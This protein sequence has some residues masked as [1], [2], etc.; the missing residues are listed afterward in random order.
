[1]EHAE[2]R[3]LLEIAAVEPGGFDRLAAGD[4]PESAALAGH[5]AGCDVCAAELERLRRA[6]LVIRDALRTAPP[7]ELRDR[8]LAFVAAVGR[9]R[10]G[11]MAEGATADRRAGEP[12]APSAGGRFAPGPGLWAASLAAAVVIAILGTSLL[13]GGSRDTVIQTQATQ[14]ASLAKAAAWSLRIDAQPDAKYVELAA[15]NGTPGVAGTLA[16]S[17]RSK[18][19]VV[20]AEGLEHPPPGMQYRCWV[21]IDGSRRRIG[22]MF[23]GG[24]VAYWVGAVDEI[25]G[26]GPGTRF[27]VSLVPADGDSLSTEPVLAGGL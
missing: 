18:E 11:A 15:P 4:T 8:T 25:A 26:V 5:I 10:G 7:P 14:I 9:P 13:V 24:D 23:F 16:F 6:S 3:E 1:M 20:L 21:E 27:G 17:P 12:A 22:Q 2:A 19:L